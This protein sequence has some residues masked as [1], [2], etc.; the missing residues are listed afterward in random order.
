MNRTLLATALFAFIALP[1]TTVSSQSKP[2]TVSPQAWQV[3]QQAI[4]LDTHLDTP[5]NFA[6]PGWNILDN[7]TGDGSR[8]QVDL[9]RMKQGG[10]DGGFFAVFTEQGP[11][12]EAGNHAARDHGLQRLMEIREM[13]AANPD[14]FELATTA[15]DAIC[16]EK[17]GKRVVFISMENASPLASDPSLLDFYYKQGLRMVG[18]AHF[19]NND[20]GDSSTDPKGVEWHG[21]SPKGRELVARANH[22]GIVLDASHS[23][24]DVLDQLLELSKAPIVLSH[25]A[26][27]AIFN[28]PR[29]VDDERLRKLAAK[30]GLIHVNAYGGYLIDL[31]KNPQRQT[32]LDTL[33]KK[34]GPEEQMVDELQIKARQREEVAIDAKYPAPKA[35]ID[36]FMRHLLHILDVVGPQHVG[37]GADWDGGGGVEGLADVSALSQITDRLLKAGYSEQDIDDIWGGNL[38]RVLSQVQAV[39]GS[40][41]G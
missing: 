31:P 14:S 17:S 13:L 20:F 9:P 24:D 37:I 1:A 19:L 23:S 21:L 35:S 26:S 28:H 34:Y 33:E 15:D 18:V 30:G 39:A 4:V 16:I 6:R 36:D 29:N 32:A 11:R 3:H 40:G 41:K 22:L 8:S 27:K 10:L 12:D 7:H 5:A 25:S 38:L 2:D